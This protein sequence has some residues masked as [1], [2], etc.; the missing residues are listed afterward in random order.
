MDDSNS[1]T[2]YFDLPPNSV[3]EYIKRYDTRHGVR[4]FLATRLAGGDK[5]SRDVH[6]RR[7]TALLRGHGSSGDGIEM[8]AARRTHCVIIRT[9]TVPLVHA[10]GRSGTHEALEAYWGICG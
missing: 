7:M 5:E 1:T 9:P 8:D 6:T 10:S 3:M 2:D 4:G